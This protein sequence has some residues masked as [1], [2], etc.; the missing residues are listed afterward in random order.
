GE[1][2]LEEGDSITLTI[3]PNPGYRID[4]VL[5]DNS[6]DI[7][8]RNSGEV[9]FAAVDADHAVRIRFAPIEFLLETAVLTDDG[10][11]LSFAIGRQPE[12]NA[13]FYDDTVKL[14]APTDN[15]YRFVE[16][17]ENGVRLSKNNPYT[18]TMRG[19]RTITALYGI[20]MCTL[21]V[22]SSPSEGGSVSIDKETANKTIV[23]QG[24]SL[25]LEAKANDYYSFV[26][27][28]QDA[29]GTDRSTT[30]TMSDNKTVTAN[31]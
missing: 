5:V 13:Y 18:V 11:P 19:N 16:W 4:S 29:G 1:S 21:S 17:R 6:L 30:I 10:E 15:A 7:S 26:G 14:T 31:F 2:R 3:T 9:T 8:A 12:R 28:T 24:T 20:K 22:T 23:E 25:L 27:W